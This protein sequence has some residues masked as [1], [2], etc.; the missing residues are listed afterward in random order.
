M[1]RTALVTVARQALEAVRC[2]SAGET[3]IV[4]LSGGADSVALLDVL[5]TL[6]GERGFGVEAAH[7]DHGLRPDSAADAAFCR[8]L[9]RVFGVRLHEGVADVAG[10]ACRERRGVEDAARRERYAFLLQ[11]RAAAGARAVAVAHTRDD[12]AETVLLRLLRGAGPAGL[13]AM[14]TRRGALLR[15]LLAASR[16]QV[17]AHLRERG[18]TWR[19]D[20]TNADPRF[21]RNRVRAELL[22]YLEQRFNPRVREALAAAAALAAEESDL[23]ER[24]SR[25]WLARHA[26]RQGGAVLLPVPALARRPK[27]LAR[28]ILRGALAA[29]GC[30]AGRIHIERLLALCRGGRASGRRLSLPEGREAV[31]RFA[32]LRIG[33]ARAPQPAF[34]SPLAVPGRV[35]LPDGAAIVARPASG[36]ARDGAQRAVLATPEGPLT[37]RTRRPGDRVR[38]GGRDVSLKRWLMAG[39]VPH[40]LRDGLPL[41][42]A[43]ADVL[44]VPGLQRQPGRAR[45]RRFVEVELVEG[46]R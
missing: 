9:C 13:A 37:V 28:R 15:P 27:A 21:A 11:V 44:W 1:A 29:A 46:A 42:A 12:Q 43:G 8:E 23:V 20:A 6:A 38:S 22:P 36:P 34:A 14:R 10:R 35:A 7:L 45:T 17:L 16:Q 3:L 5:V 33:S 2:P 30:A 18:L 39:R 40:D 32:E 25:T 24:Q 4:G 31:F 19:E 41:V 26:R